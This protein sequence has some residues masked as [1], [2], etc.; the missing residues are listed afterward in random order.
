V[1]TTG[2]TVGVAEAMVVGFGAWMGVW[3]GWVVGVGLR[4]EVVEG[5]DGDGGRCG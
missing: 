2:Q 5:R 4:E 1:P 3:G